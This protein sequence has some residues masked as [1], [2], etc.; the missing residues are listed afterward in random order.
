M[1]I[2]RIWKINDSELI[3]LKRA[4]PIEAQ[5]ED[6]IEKD[7]SIIS[8]YLILIGR[9]VSTD[10]GGVI[11]LLAIDRGGNVVVI[12]LKKEKTPRTVVAQVLD[13]ASWISE[14]QPDRLL[15][16]AS[17]Y[18]QNNFEDVFKEKMGIDLTEINPEPKMLIVSIDTDETTR[19]VVKFLSEKYGVSINI[20]NFDLFEDENGNKYLLRTFLM[21][22]VEVERKSE[23]REKRRKINKAIFLSACNANEKNLFERIFEFADIKGLRYS[24]GR[25]GCSIRVPFKERDVFLLYCYSPLAS[26]GTQ[27]YVTIGEIERALGESEKIT[28][29]FLDTG[30]FLEAGESLRIDSSKELSEGDIDKIISLLDE[31][32]EKLKRFGK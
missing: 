18:H 15:E 11:D 1:E 7:I 28:K 24:W 26:F 12:E 2:S 20:V 14:L 31:I 32:A 6:W 16:I 30:L 22:P 3:E 27:L 4:S 5:L 25:T 29:R 8:P 9:Q 13:Y 10:F 19:R 23:E 21:D 17:N